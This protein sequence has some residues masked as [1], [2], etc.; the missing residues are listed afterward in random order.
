MLATI[1]SGAVY[2]EVRKVRG[3]LPIALMARDSG[4]QRLLVPAHN[5]EEAAVAEGLDVYPVNTLRDAADFLDQE[6][7]LDKID[8]D[9]TRLFSEDGHYDLDFEDVKGQESAKR[10][11]EVAVSGGHNILLIGPP[12]TGKSMLSKR[13]R[14]QPRTSRRIISR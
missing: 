12:G 2:G 9:T 4:C 6:L 5:A 10:A 13:M 11:L 7:E 14:S 8:M 1:Q 3:V